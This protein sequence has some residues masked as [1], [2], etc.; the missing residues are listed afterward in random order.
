ME[1]IKPIVTKNAASFE[2]MSKLK[3][4]KAIPD[5]IAKISGLQTVLKC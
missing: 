5:V 4:D 2:S 1:T 3:S